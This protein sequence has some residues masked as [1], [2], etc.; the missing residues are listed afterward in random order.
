LEFSGGCSL[1]LLAPPD[2]MEDIDIDLT[3]KR[4]TVMTCSWTNF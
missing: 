3:S 2:C 1:L 4:H